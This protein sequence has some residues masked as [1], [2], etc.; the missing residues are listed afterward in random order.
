MFANKVEKIFCFGGLS[1]NTGI[2]ERLNTDIHVI[3]NDFVVEKCDEYKNAIFNLVE[4]FKDYH[5]PRTV[6]E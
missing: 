3:L 2:K 1:S 6:T 4:T 5:S